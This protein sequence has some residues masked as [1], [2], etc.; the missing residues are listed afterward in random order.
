[1]PPVA[2]A[3][4]E[5]SDVPTRATPPSAEP[6]GVATEDFTIFIFNEQKICAAVVKQTCFLARLCPTEKIR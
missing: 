4:A 2:V 5:D 6:G 3:K 1:M